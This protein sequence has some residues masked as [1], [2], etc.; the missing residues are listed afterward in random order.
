MLPLI[1]PKVSSPLSPENLDEEKAVERLGGWLDGGVF[2]EETGQAGRGL[3]KEEGACTH[4][5]R[6]QV[7]GVEELIVEIKIFLFQK[8][9]LKA[10][11]HPIFE[12]LETEVLCYWCV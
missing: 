8:M 5:G 11:E 9:L 3:E 4:K 2:V 1:C 10:K 12:Y 6:G 7:R